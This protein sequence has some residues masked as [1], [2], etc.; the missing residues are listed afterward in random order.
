MK[1]DNFMQG[2]GDCLK[3]SILKK[4]RKVSWCVTLSSTG[5]LKFNV[6][7]AARGKQGLAS[8]GGVLRNHKGEVMYMFSKHVGIKDSN[9]A[10][11]LVILEALRIYHPF[12]HHYLIVESDSA[13][14]IFWV[15]ALKGPWK[16]QFFFNENSLLVSELHI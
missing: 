2:W 13:N 8:I 4:K 12:C 10:E 3:K 7:G 5:V 6:D 9:E 16:M 15:K 11:V 1:M 14:A